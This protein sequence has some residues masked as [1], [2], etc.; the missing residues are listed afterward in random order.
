MSQRRQCDLI[1][2][3]RRRGFTQVE[4]IDNDLGG[5]ASG[6]V[7]RAGFIEI[8]GSSKVHSP[9]LGAAQCRQRHNQEAL[10]SILDSAKRI[11]LTKAIRRRRA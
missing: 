2:E 10:L 7:A 6:T 3:A 5:A 11:Q 1:E 4:V 9:R 8:V